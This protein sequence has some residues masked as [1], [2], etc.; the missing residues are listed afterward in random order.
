MTLLTMGA[1][2]QD[3]FHC[4]IPSKFAPQPEAGARKIERATRAALPA[5]R[6]ALAEK[7]CGRPGGT[8][9]AA[10]VPGGGR[11]AGCD[12]RRFGR[13]LGTLGSGST[14]C[15]AARSSRAHGSAARPLRCSGQ[16]DRSRSLNSSRQSPATIGKLKAQ[17]AIDLAAE[18]RD[19]ADVKQFIC[20]VL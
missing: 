12:N 5:L 13:A 9:P 10:C 6:T 3:K 20:S 14:P 18:A 15:R 4:E 11:N 19:W 2:V 1:R 16:A 8:R 7:G 17:H